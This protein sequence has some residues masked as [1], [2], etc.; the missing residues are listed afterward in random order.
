MKRSGLS[1]KDAQS[2]RKWR[3]KLQGGGHPAKIPVRYS[4]GM[5]SRKSVFTAVVR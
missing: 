2:L 1:Q 4:K 5:L 3:K